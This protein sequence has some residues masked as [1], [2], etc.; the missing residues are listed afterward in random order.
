MYRSGINNNLVCFG[1]SVLLLSL[2]IYFIVPLIR[3]SYYQPSVQKSSS[4]DFIEM[5]MSIPLDCLDECIKKVKSYPT[6]FEKFHFVYQKFLGHNN[7]MKWKSSEKG[8]LIMGALLFSALTVAVVVMLNCVSYISASL[9]TILLVTIYHLK[10]EVWCFDNIML[11]IA[12]TFLAFDY[13]SYKQSFVL[14][15][16]SVCLCYYMAREMFFKP[17]SQRGMIN[18]WT[19]WG[20]ECSLGCDV[21][22]EANVQHRLAVFEAQQQT[23]I[24]KV[25]AL[26]LAV[27]SAVNNGPRCPNCIS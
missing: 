8:T 5:I 25:E 26:S 12:L 10:G 23:L 4:W 14:I 3:L 18:T 13:L 22:T 11:F 1:L 24:A 9:F 19:N 21:S 2:I 17:K 16:T 6:V 15:A 20:Q 27:Q 7:I